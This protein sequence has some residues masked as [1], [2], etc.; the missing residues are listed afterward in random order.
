MMSNGK[1]IEAAD[2]DQNFLQTNNMACV[3]Q[4]GVCCTVLKLNE[5]LLFEGRLRRQKP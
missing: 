4:L 3:T 1:L 2:N 5:N